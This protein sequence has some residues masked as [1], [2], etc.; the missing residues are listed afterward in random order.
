MR[1][2]RKSSLLQLLEPGGQYFFNFPVALYVQLIGV[3]TPGQE[4]TANLCEKSVA[5]GENCNNRD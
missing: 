2:W 1:R 3:R 5:L 4:V